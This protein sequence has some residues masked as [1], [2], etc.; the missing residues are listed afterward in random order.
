MN[1]VK[2]TPGYAGD[3]YFREVVVA[4]TDSKNTLHKKVLERVLVPGQN[5]SDTHDKACHIRAALYEYWSTRSEEVFAE[6]F[7]KIETYIGDTY[8]EFGVGYEL[9]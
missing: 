2:M 8:H 7:N 6:G 1:K 4:A 5:K 9:I 3:N